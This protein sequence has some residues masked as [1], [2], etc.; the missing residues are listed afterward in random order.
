LKKELTG[1][2]IKVSLF[3]FNKFSGVNKEPEDPDFR[4]LYKDRSMY[5]SK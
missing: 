5:W 4:Q 2:A 1:F 3:S